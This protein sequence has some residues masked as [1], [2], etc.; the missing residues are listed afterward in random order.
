MDEMSKRN[1]VEMRTEELFHWIKERWT[2]RQARASGKAKPWTTDPILRQYRFC[3]VH[4]EDDTV[5]RWITDNWRTPH[6]DDPDFWFAAYVARVFN[7]PTTLTRV[8]YPVPYTARVRKRM[9]TLTGKTFNAAYIV[10]T[11]GVKTDKLTYYTTVFDNVWVARKDLRPK[12]GEPLQAFAAR[13]V[14]VNAVGTFMAGQVIADA[15]YAGVLR[16]APDWSTFAVSGPGS[17]RGL[18]WVCGREFDA[19]WLEP[20]W[21]ARLLDLKPLVDVF[22][23][24]NKIP[25]IHA[26][27][28]QNCLCE[29]H[30]MVKVLQGWGRPKCLYPGV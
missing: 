15:K 2:V 17:R 1:G 12:A 5:T 26:Q 16:K 4:R 18:N 30:K 10:S 6:S 25:P 21:H 23:K 14:Q 27:D 13:L 20:E 19:P 22:A 9:T 11:N 3:N 28:L 8:G 7:L 24:K 29:L